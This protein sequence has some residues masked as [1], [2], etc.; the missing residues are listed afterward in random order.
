MAIIKQTETFFK[1]FGSIRPTGGGKDITRRRISCK[2]FL[3]FFFFLVQL[4]IYVLGLVKIYF[5][6]TFHIMSFG[7]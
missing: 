6:N 4:H 5:I 3:F 1:R 2:Q 7:V